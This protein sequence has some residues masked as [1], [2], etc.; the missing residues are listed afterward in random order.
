VE[1]GT[2]VVDELLKMSLENLDEE[3]RV[4]VLRRLAEQAM[5]DLE[6]RAVAREDLL[7]ALDQFGYDLNPPEMALVLRFRAAL[8]EAGIDLFLEGPISDEYTQLLKQTL[9]K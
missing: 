9:P 5:T 1:R 3:V 7:A 6:F 2:T 8:A 4:D